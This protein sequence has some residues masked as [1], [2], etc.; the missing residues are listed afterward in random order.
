M[1]IFLLTAGFFAAFMLIGHSTIGRRQFF[2]PMKE[3]TFDPTAKRVMEFV[4]HMSTAA[5]L[6]PPFILAY[7]GVKGVD[8][9]GLGFLITYIALQFALWGGV[10]FLVV[11]TS[12][13]PGA[14]YKMFQWALFLMV[15]GFAFLGLS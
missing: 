2:L 4:W 5:L 3:A 10:H 14:I 15:G 13:L 7:A 1:N 9:S 12:G 8:G 11:S 6:L